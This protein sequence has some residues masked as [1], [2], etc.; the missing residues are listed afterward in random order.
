MNEIRPISYRL[1]LEPDLEGFQFA[2]AIDIFAEAVGQTGEVILEA[3]DLS[4]SS[5]MA[6][7]NQRVLDCRFSL[8]PEAE[9]LKV[10]LPEK[11][12]GELRLRIEYSGNINDKMAGFY[13]SSYT[14]DG[15]TK[16]IAVTQFEE[17]DAR[18]AFPC[19]DHPA[20][21]A[22]FDIEMIIDQGHTAISNAPIM[23][24]EHLNNGKK[25]VRFEP[26]PRMSTYLV[27]FSVGE[28]EFIEDEK[29]P[30]LRVAA[31][32]GMANRGRLGL[33]FGQKSLSLCEEIF[34]IPYPL[35][36]L[37]L[38]AI[39]DFAFGAM[40]N[41][42]AITFRENLLLNFPGITSRA[43]EENIF[44]VIAHEIVHQW[45]GNLVTPSDWKYLWLNESFAT[46]L[47]HVHTALALE[48]DS[49]NETFP[50]EIPGGEH[51]VI[52]ASTAPIIYNKGG[53]ILEQ[54][55]AYLGKDEF[56]KGIKQ[57]LQ[58]H[59]YGCAASRDL[60]EAFETASE[61]PVTSIMKSWIEQPGF[62]LLDVD[63][64]GDRLTIRQRRFT[65][66]PNQSGQVWLV[67]VSVRLYDASGGSRTITRLIDSESSDI[68]LD[69]GAVAYK[70]NADQKGFYRVRY[71]DRAN[72]DE[73]GK[74]IK[75]MPPRDRWGLQNDLYALVKGAEAEMD[76]YL[77]FLLY[78]ENENS[79]LPLISISDNLHHAWLVM[80][81]RKKEKI[82]SVGRSLFE[83][84]LINIGLEPRSDERHAISILRDHI[85]W[86]AALFNSK[87]AE[88][89]GAGRFESLMT[90]A[91]VHQDILRAVMQIGAMHGC[92]GAFEWLTR[93]FETSR[94]EHERMNILTA[95]GSFRD[96]SDIQSTLAYVLDKVPL[97]N[98]FI[99]VGS[100]AG[101]PH[102]IVS[103]WQWYVSNLEALEQLHPL[104]YERIIASIIPMAGLGREKSV[105]DFFDEYMKQKDTARDVIKLSLERL[106]VNSRMRANA[107]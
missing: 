30:R 47:A 61:R 100:M 9:K 53:S 102:A 84:A 34:G 68:D 20:K 75:Q 35:A 15:K 87:M 78:Y 42:G 106:K 45:F 8:E 58:D 4:I 52:N 104:H 83:R 82:S 81:G 41:W 7:V 2:G 32:P 64:N 16:T 56:K 22:A 17:S 74:R 50:I 77:A 89:F 105:T 11:I 59:G 72:L 93:R 43:G 69:K 6:F 65:F 23:L 19:L 28:F 27:F 37:D 54:I 25:K 13:R 86:R 79:F 96:S 12:T 31:T 62:P 76:E 49:L 85:L 57:F 1:S 33:D 10:Y 51:V 29:D 40:E 63:R 39:Q 73:L 55:E 92:A 99:P 14:V 71:R 60:W 18:R 48:R 91:P 5:C 90:G 44:N 80:E 36:K 67:P 3:L 95:I 66:L 101:N 98:R 97:R 46:Y 70:V 24:E 107:S 26:T 88:D 21:K 103:L 94:S 38:I